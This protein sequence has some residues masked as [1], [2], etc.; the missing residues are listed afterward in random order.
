VHLAVLVLFWSRTR[1]AVKLSWTLQSEL[2]TAL[3]LAAPLLIGTAALQV[4]QSLAR[5][6]AAGLGPG[7]VTALDY[8]YRVTNA[9]V[10]VS[11]SGV[12]LVVLSDWS[13]TVVS[14][15]SSALRRKL[16]NVLLLVM[17][18]LLP[19]V[20][21]LHALRVP[22]VTMWLERS[23]VAPGFIALTAGILGYWLLGIPLDIASRVYAR[24]FLVW[25]RTSVFAW[26]AL[27]RLGLSAILFFVLTPV[28][29]V[30]GIAVGD[31]LGVCL[32]L[33]G[34]ALAARP[35]LAGPVPGIAASVGRL[36]AASA[37]TW[38]VTRMIASV[39]AT[40]SPVLVILIGSA[41]A[42]I[43]YVLLTWALRVDELRTL[44]KTAIAWRAGGAQT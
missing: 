13:A 3:R 35:Y 32:T 10:E 18:T 23:G 4:G 17:F 27:G 6:V 33:G 15:D 1:T 28:L 8:A 44:W 37:A 19:V 30:P 25:Q 43:S 20:F 29:G 38:V 14:G 39:L 2:R 42:G 7:S 12:L 16:R 40:R 41:A 31:V 34:L 22:V 36:A 5:F 11:S 26:L 24:A 21:V 9:V